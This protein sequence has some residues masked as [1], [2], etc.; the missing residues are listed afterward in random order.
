M[1]GIPGYI[2]QGGYMGGIPGYIPLYVHLGSTPRYIPPYTLWVYPRIAHT[3]AH[4]SAVVQAEQR[5][6]EEALGSSLRIVRD[7]EAHSALF[8]SKV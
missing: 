4:C 2:Q 1:G 6:G 7:N 8:S 5:G 3:H